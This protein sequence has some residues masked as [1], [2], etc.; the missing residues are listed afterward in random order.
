MTFR[1]DTHPVRRQKLYEQIVDHLESMMLSGDL[2]IGDR[3][4]SERK[5]M[6]IFQVGRPSVREAL[7]ALQRK[8]LV[9]LRNGEQA[10]VTRP[11]ARGMI[12]NLSGVVRHMLLQPEGTREFQQAR[13]I[14]EVSLA[15]H[16]ARHATDEDIRDL[17]EA[18]D[19]NG[20]AIGQS[21]EFVKTDV[22][23]HFVIACSARNSIFRALHEAVSDWLAEQRQISTRH[24][25]AERAAF[26][27]HQKIFAAIKTHDADAAEQA[28]QFHLEEVAEF[29]WS[30]KISQP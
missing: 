7:F 18:L 11:S 20:A 28:M 27:A 22:A 14:L 2:A 13:M 30:S 6:E 16:A 23:F 8:E 5:L 24:K 29:Y 19:R 26:E 25:K 10:C 4:P 17:A 3:L 15:R 21:S 9:S 1:I 12:G